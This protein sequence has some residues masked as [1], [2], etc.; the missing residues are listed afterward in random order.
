[1]WIW[2]YDRHGC[3]Q[4][5]GIDFIQDR[6]RLLILLFALQRFSLKEWGFDISLDPEVESLHSGILQQSNSTSHFK[7][8][9]QSTLHPSAPMDVA[10]KVQDR[11]SRYTL[12]G[13]GT[14]VLKSE[15]SNVIGKVYW[16]NTS[17]QPEHE[18][19]AHIHNINKTKSL[20]LSDYL[21]RVLGFK[22]IGH[23]T[24]I[25]RDAVGSE[26]SPPPSEDMS[27]LPTSPREMW[28]M[29]SEKL[30]PVVGHEGDDG[31]LSCWFQAVICESMQPQISQYVRAGA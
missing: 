7:V 1:M 28:L 9:V 30:A 21:P 26:P 25:I 13:R 29:V 17:R 27:P 6:T 4:T 15:K 19:V 31:F 8:S 14:V 24:Q 16:P 12:M 3:I 20:G 11:E 23:N 5:Q 22:R 10:L 2:W 18:I